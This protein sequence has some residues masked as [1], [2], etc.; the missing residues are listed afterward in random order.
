MIKG[1]F[2]KFFRDLKLDNWISGILMN[3]YTII[4][5]T[6]K[7]HY[8]KKLMKNIDNFYFARSRWFFKR[9]YPDCA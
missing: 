6:G 2:G 1:K 9:R 4:T 7:C 3:V 8:L 5:Q